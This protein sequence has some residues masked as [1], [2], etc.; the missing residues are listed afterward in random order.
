MPQAENTEASAGTT[1]LVTP[2]SWASATACIA[3][4]PPNAISVKS[5]GSNPR[6]TET[7]LSAL[8]MLL[9]AM[10]TMPRAASSASTPS[11]DPTASI[12]FATASMS[13]CTVPPQK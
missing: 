11:R 9:L 5:R 2:S 13:A 8:T 7:S 10:R 12:A 3:P 1:T 6:L 4:P